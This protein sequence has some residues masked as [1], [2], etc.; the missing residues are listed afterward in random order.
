MIKIR[1]TRATSIRIYTMC[2]K[3]KNLQVYAILQ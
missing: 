3:G 2:D 1:Q